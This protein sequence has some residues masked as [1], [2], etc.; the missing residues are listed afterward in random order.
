MV[1]HIA[2]L[3]ILH[4]AVEAGEL[5]QAQPSLMVQKVALG[6]PSVDFF[7]E[8]RDLHGGRFLMIISHFFFLDAVGIRL[9]RRPHL[10]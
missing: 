1:L 3:A 10:A 5:L 2:Q 4:V 6:E 8:I 7:L 9:P